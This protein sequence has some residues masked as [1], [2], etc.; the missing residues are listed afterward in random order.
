M[1][2]ITFYENH[3][4]FSCRSSAIFSNH[5]S[6][7]CNYS[8]WNWFSVSRGEKKTL[9]QAPI[10]PQTFCGRIKSKRLWLFCLLCFRSIIIIKFSLLN[11]FQITIFVKM[12]GCD[13]NNIVSR[14]LPEPYHHH[15][16]QVQYIFYN[17]LVE[18]KKFNL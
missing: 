18:N 3:Y 4:F 13:S 2:I 11:I 17:S 8:S 9:I 6:T 5:C 10:G 15:F 14:S 16:E 1:I 7:V 12:S